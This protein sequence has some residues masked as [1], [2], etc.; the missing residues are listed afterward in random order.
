[1]P[2][3]RV[4]V[5]SLLGAA[6]SLGCGGPGFDPD[7]DPVTDG[8]WYRPRSETTW[9]WQLSG[10]PNL[11]YDVE[12]YDLDLFDTDEATISE[13]HDQGRRVICYFSGGSSEDW[14]PDYERFTGQD[15]GY[16]LDG[17][18]GERW[19]DIRSEEVLAI[20]LDRLDLAVDKGCDGVEPDNMDG[21]T[22][23]TG[24]RLSE[25]D[26]LGYNR[27][28]ANEAHL[29]DLSVALKND[30][31]QASALVDYFDLSVN[32]Q[33]HEFAECGQ[34][35]PF[36]DADKPIFNAE[37]PG[38]AS[39]AEAKRQSVCERAAAAGTRTLMLPLDLDDSFRVSCD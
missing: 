19:L 10:T 23:R 20:M 36:R 1:M 25:D 12:V 2:D 18:A 37:Y 29:R 30:G 21:F 39:A 14:R 27:R 26:Q 6:T 3:P 31:D 13:L 9:Q 22:N 11:E 16:K 15:K 24:F 8:S 38:S 5:L 4:L 34:L 17:W 32:E 35:A 28:L 7:V 33:C